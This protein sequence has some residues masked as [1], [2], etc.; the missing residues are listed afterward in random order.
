MVDIDLETVIKFCDKFETEYLE[1]LHVNAARL[2]K[3]ASSAASTLGK[4]DMATNAT[5]K[6]EKVADAIYK[7]SMVGEERIQ[8]LRRKAQQE[9]DDKE[10]IENSMSR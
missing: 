5:E 7:A 1:E 6:L 8:E 9:L 10:R 2:K 4:T 3:A